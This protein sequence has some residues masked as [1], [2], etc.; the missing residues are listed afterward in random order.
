MS[1]VANQHFKLR[2]IPVFM[3]NVAAGETGGEIE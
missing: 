1:A 2:A 3:L